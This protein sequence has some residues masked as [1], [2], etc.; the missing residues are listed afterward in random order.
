MLT[1]GAVF[2]LFNAIL[3]RRYITRFA[4][5]RK[6]VALKFPLSFTLLCA[7]TLSGCAA[8]NYTALDAPIAQAAI[9]PLSPRPK[10]AIVLGAGRPRG[11]AHVGVIKAL[12]ANGVV[13]DLIVGSSVGALIGSFWASG[14]SA[15]QIEARSQEGGP[16]TLFDISLFADRGWIRGK[17]L[18]D[19]VNAELAGKKLEQFAKPMIVVATRRDT[20]ASTFFTQG[21]AGVA[22]RASSAVPGVIS[23]VG[24]V[25]VEYEDADVSLP[26]AVSAARAAGAQFVIAVDV[27]AYEA[28]TPADAKPE[29]RARDAAGRTRIAPEVAQA[30]FLIHPDLGYTASPRRA[31]FEM[32]AR[33][34]EETA[35]GQIAALKAKLAERFGGVVVK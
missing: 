30:D 11:Y 7:L 2:T 9:A 33:V 6:H 19:Y 20:K 28:S 34:G 21:N 4:L 1:C 15:A 12:E 13:P 29:W 24:I 14:V 18:Q 35:R 27:S 25:G 32:A 26:V 31:Y 16:L 23:P 8:F 17:R 10:I 5:T 3:R 22:V